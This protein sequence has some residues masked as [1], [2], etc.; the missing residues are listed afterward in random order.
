MQIG[1]TDYP[2][3]TTS[4]TT[5]HI[6]ANDTSC[7]LLRSKLWITSLNFFFPTSN[8]LIT[9]YTQNLYPQ[10]PT[11]LIRG[12][13]LSGLVYIKDL[14]TSPLTPPFLAWSQSIVNKA[15][16]RRQE[17]Q[18]SRGII[19]KPVRSI[20]S[21]LFQNSAVFAPNK[22]QIVGNNTKQISSFDL[23]DPA[24]SLSY[25]CSHNRVQQQS[26]NISS[27]MPG[28]LLTQGV[29][30]GCPPVCYVSS[31]GMHMPVSLPS[32]SIESNAPF[33]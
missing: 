8:W 6:S 31:Q 10:K 3:T 28:T 32:S 30:S 16:R 18:K 1:N 13:I 4:P 5:S 25:C 22:K 24:L 14:V 11:T 9:N 26:P 17:M 21:Y 19:L 20:L 7:Q 12:T 15:V 33:H 23:Q 29:C 2:S 27:N